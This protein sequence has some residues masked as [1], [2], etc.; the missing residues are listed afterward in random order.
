[1]KGLVAFRITNFRSVVDTG[2]VELSRDQVTV[3][4]G[5]NE[6]GKSSVLQALNCALGTA[7]VTADDRRVGAPDPVIYLRVRTSFDALDEE[8]L[9]DFRGAHITGLHQYLEAMEGTV[10]L[11]C[12]RTAKSSPGALTELEVSL[13]DETGFAEALRLA[14]EQEEKE[15]IGL[16]IGKGDESSESPRSLDSRSAALLIH[17]SLP[18]ATLFDAETGLLPNTV[19][20]DEKGRPT[21][22][23]AV[24]ATNFLSIA[25]ID[26]P[27]LVKGD[28]RY[29]QNVLNRANQ[30]V[31]EDFASF[32]SQVIGAKSKLTL[33]CGFE[34][35]SSLYEK[36]GK[37]YLEFWISD[38]NTQLY[39]KQRSQGVRWF[40]SFYLQLRATE[41]S[42]H[43]RLFLLDEP[44]ANLHEKA[45]EDVLRLIDKLRRDIPI[46]YSTHSPKMIE[47]E[48]LFRI[49]AVQRDGNEE[50]SPTIV[51]DAQHLGAA[52]SDTLSPLLA[53]MGSDMSHQA[54]VKSRRNV[55][56]EE[57]SGYYYLTAFWKL[58]ECTEEVYF[59]A[60]TGVN[61][62]PL[63]A[64]MFLGWGLDFVVAVDD[65]KQGREVYNQLKKDLCGDREDLAERR[66]LKFPGCTAIE[67]VFSVADFKKYVIKNEDA[68]VAGSNAEHM[69]SARLSKPVA[70][71]EFMLSVQ[72]GRVKASHL[73][74]ITLGKMRGLIAA[75]SSLLSRRDE[76]LAIR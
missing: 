47:Y 4:V 57:I 37:P 31:S 27:A 44:G 39:P 18:L 20:I 64:N 58:L 56:L 42:R 6:S 54:V 16:E 17:H 2:W 45:Q 60:A 8:E 41:K 19:D 66:L 30:R 63:L 65:D 22:Q 72:E 53:A 70:A 24:A 68:T 21:G 13:L 14:D 61:K 48:K 40:V 67:E 23:G 5:Q 62:V 9:S 55:L 75:I 50:D 36:V 26:L 25:E 1:M 59:I 74:Q 33:Q 69:K 49:R 76:E 7:A 12:R 28:G 10:E 32:W 3:L 52:S 35:Y 29:R 46:V 34:F 15:R 38:G 71:L 43:P 11:V 73:D 51:I